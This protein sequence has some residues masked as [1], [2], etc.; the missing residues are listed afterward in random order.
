MKEWISMD[1]GGYMGG[2]LSIFIVSP[3]KEALR[4]LQMVDAGV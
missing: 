1:P 4:S 3:L 2:S